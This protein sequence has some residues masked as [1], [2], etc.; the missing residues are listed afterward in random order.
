[1]IQVSDARGANRYISET[2]IWNAE[3]SLY[4]YVLV[5]CPILFVAAVGLQHIP[6]HQLQNLVNGNPYEMD[7]QYS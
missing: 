2:V 3:G 1:M 6:F 5:F 4:S 7:W